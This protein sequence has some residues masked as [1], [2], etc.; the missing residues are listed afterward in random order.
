VPF[1]LYLLR[2]GRADVISGWLHKSKMFMLDGGICPVSVNMFRMLVR[3][4]CIS[5]VLSLM[6]WVQK[7]SRI[8]G[9]H[10]MKP[11]TV[12]LKGMRF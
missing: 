2:P 5:K 10:D 4:I 9:A 3:V 11:S 6:L 1:S 8:A 7:V 12:R